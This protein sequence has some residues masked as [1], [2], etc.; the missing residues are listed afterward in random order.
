METFVKELADDLV[1]IREQKP[2]IHHI[3][4]FVVMNETANMTLCLGALPVM[5]HAREEVEEM[6]GF[7]GALVLNIGTLTPELIE[8]MI[9]AGKKA[10]EL[11][12][13]VVLDPV[14]AGATA[15]RTDA[16]KSLLKEVNMAVIRGNSAEIGILAGAGGEIKGVEAIGKNEH[17]VDAARSLA[18]SE[19]CVVSV[20]GA[21]DIITDG[22]RIAFVRNGDAMMATITG[23]GCMST[24]I[25]AG[26]TAVQNDYFKAATG[27]LVAFG[28]AGEKAAASTQGKPGSFHAVLYDE[29]YALDADAI[30]KGANLEIELPV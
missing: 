5:A 29:V 23:T 3:T 22:E 17:I 19:G 27:A 7:A 14:G 4:N 24:T 16:V 8:S 28:I 26:F 30:I 15:L 21:E 12:V 2:L 13:P 18:Q 6:V 20:T 1:K 9:I 10:N 25:T 11:G